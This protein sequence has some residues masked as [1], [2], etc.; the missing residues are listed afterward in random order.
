MSKEEIMFNWF[1][2]V[3]DVIINYFSNTGRKF[4]NNSLFQQNLMTNF[5][6]TLETFNQSKNVTTME[7]QSNGKHNIFG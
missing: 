1:G 7:R 2:Y 5:G 4:N 6:Q 3:K